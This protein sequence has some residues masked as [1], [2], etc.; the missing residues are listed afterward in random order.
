MDYIKI[1]RERKTPA[2]TLTDLHR[3]TAFDMFVREGIPDKNIEKYRYTPLKEIFDAE[4]QY[5]SGENAVISNEMKEKVISLIPAFDAHVIFTVNGFVE[6]SSPDTVEGMTFGS[7]SNACKSLPETLSKHYNSLA[8]KSGALA[9]LNTA[10]ANDGVFL[11]TEKGISVSKPL[12]IIN[13]TTS[14]SPLFTQQRNLFVVEE[15]SCA[16]VIIFNIN[17]ADDRILANNLTEIVAQKG[18]RLDIV[19][20]Q[21]DI[22]S[23]NS[24]LS[25]ISS[26]FVKQESDSALTYTNISFGGAL[27]CNDTEVRLAG[28]RC[29]N[30]LYGLTLAGGKQHVDNH[31]FVEHAVPS[32]TSNELYKSIVGGRAVNVFNGRILVCRDAQKTSA[33]Q[34]NKNVLLSGDAKVYAK[35]QLE[36]YADD[37]KCS[38]GATTGKLDEE[39]LFYMQARGIPEKQARLLLMSGFAGEILS[40]IPVAELRDSLADMVYESLSTLY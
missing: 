29:E 21:S 13:I 11:R 20:I 15:N 33:F 40:K 27:L 31:T 7:L 32:C 38:H 16:Q 23:K 17:C 26:D 2:S 12:L 25:Q 6:N 1:Y 19:R 10:L 39:A 3:Q 36:I 14:H 8:V 9:S 18:S 34:S 4:Y 24:L 37:V 30:H 35:P 28:E 5:V 22:F